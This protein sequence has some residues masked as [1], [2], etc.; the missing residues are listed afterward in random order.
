MVFLPEQPTLED[1]GAVFRIM[2]DG[3]RD[4][5]SRWTQAYHGTN[6]INMISIMEEGFALP[7]SKEDVVHGGAG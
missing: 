5:L 6:I 7:T 4:A 3:E 2:P 1:G